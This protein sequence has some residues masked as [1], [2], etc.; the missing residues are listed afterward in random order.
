MLRGNARAPVV[1]DDGVGKARVDLLGSAAGSFGWRARACCLRD[2]L[3]HWL[4]E[5]PRANLSCRQCKWKG[6]CTRRVC[7]F[8]GIPTIDAPTAAVRGSR[9]ARSGS[10]QCEKPPPVSA[11]RIDRLRTRFGG[12][13][14]NGEMSGRQAIGCPCDAIFRVVCGVWPRWLNLIPSC[15]QAVWLLSSTKRV[16]S[17]CRASQ[18]S[19][20][21]GKPDPGRRRAVPPRLPP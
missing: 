6:V 20:S 7:V 2:N 15:P 5:V 16:L 3:H 11:A 1:V 13:C 19:V 4:P 21:A 14:D 10:M 12:C 17:C 18:A 8:P 9:G